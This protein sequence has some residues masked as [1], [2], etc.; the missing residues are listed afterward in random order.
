M[1]NIIKFLPVIDAPAETKMPQRSTKFSAGYDFYA[2]CD[3]LVPA[4]G[5]SK[6][7]PLNIKALMPSDYV[8]QLFIRSS[9]ATKHNL[10][11]VN[12]V[13]IIDAD[14]ADNVE[15][16]GN[17]GVKYFNHGNVDYTIKKGE[18]CAQ[19]IFLR[20][21]VTVDDEVKAIREGGYGSTGA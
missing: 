2:P 16:D 13:G 11:L 8:L 17:I 6:L 12:N 10:M 1:N 19:G 3:I 4:H 21:G 20:Y 5:V 18:R 9:L 15:N 7:V 14:Y